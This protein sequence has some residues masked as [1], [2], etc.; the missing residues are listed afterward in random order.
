MPEFF[1]DKEVVK[2]PFLFIS[3]SHSDKPLVENLARNLLDAGVRLWYDKDLAVGDPWAEKVKGLIAH[4]NCNGV[5]FVC[6][7]SAYVSDN[8]HKE[9][10]AALEIQ[11]AR[12]RENYMF[13]VVNVCSTT[14]E[15]SYMRMLKS[16][17]EQ[18]PADTIDKLFPIDRFYTLMRI[19]GIDPICVLTAD[20]EYHQ[21][22]LDGISKNVKAVIDKGAI[23]LENLQQS[24]GLNGVSFD[25]GNYNGSLKW[26]MIFRDNE[27]GWFIL[28]TPL[29]PAL[30]KNLENWLN[31]EFISTAFTKEEASLL[32]DKIRLLTERE[33]N[34]FSQ[35]I[36]LVNVAWWLKDCTG[37]RQA[38][39]QS[40]GKISKLRQLN[41]QAKRGVRP[42]IVL[43]LTDVNNLMN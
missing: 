8:I 31:K 7:P 23:A 1:S 32:T 9:R 13:F 16:T 43:H 34:D 6:S 4:P 14:N 22:L 33:F 5:I 42:I 20:V 29:E 25:F 41:H 10:D 17:F 21:K 15:G 19:I 39:V 2:A 18:Q 27:T 26:Q 36:P 35:Y 11:Q 12:G 37:A 30:G 28:Q 3:Y 38:A 40:D 24:A